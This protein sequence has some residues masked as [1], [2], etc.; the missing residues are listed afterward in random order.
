MFIYYVYAYL[1]KESLT[2]Y[3][4]GK[5]KGYRA[6]DKN[7]NVIVPQDKRRIILL[8]TNMSDIGAC[9]LERQMIRWYGRKDIN[10]GILRN[11]TDGGDG[12][13]GRPSLSKGTNISKERRDKISD[14]VKK[15]MDT[16]SSDNK[17][18]KF[19]L[20]GT[21]NGFFERK[22]TKESL[23]KM[24]TSHNI[25]RQELQHCSICQK[26]ADKQNYAKYHGN[27]CN[28]INKGVAGRKWFHDG[29]KTYYVYSTDV[30]IH[31]LSLIHGRLPTLKL[32]R[33]L[34]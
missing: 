3:Y 16:L 10:T 9:A 5:G 11:R 31:E 18:K 12:T 24:S 13:A 2:P 23:S 1:R 6:W 27:N 33:P 28:N 15:W 25:Q 30:I 8:E 7:H 34:N 32:G 20:R 21:K 26:S 17:K 4:I 14:G 19:G 29:T 22:H